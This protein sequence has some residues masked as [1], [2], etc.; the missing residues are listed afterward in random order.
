MSIKA[1]VFDMDNTIVDFLKFKEACTSVAIDAMIAKGL[2]ISKDDA[3]KMIFEMYIAYGWEN[4]E[5]FNK[6]LSVTKGNVDYKMLASAISAYRKEKQKHMRPYENV[7]PTLT[8]LKKKGIKLAILTDAPKLQ[9]YLRL[10]DIGLLD[11]FD[12]IVTFDDTGRLK[13]NPAPF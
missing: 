8:E 13:P 2:N 12:L 5:I 3:V 11:H 6:F 7:I 10:A 1:V 4:Q 9:A